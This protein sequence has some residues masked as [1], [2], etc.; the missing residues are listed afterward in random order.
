MDVMASSALSH[1]YAYEDAQ[2]MSYLVV[3]SRRIQHLSDL[4]RAHAG[5]VAN[6]VEHKRRIAELKKET[7][8]FGLEYDLLMSEKMAMEQVW[9]TL[10]VNVDSLTKYNEGLMIH[11]ESLSTMLLTGIGLL[12]RPGL[13]LRHCAGTMIGFCRLGLYALW[14]S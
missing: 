14:I 11:N 6:E 2:A 13:K 8:S 5:F 1:N 4:E 9:S 3:G 7:L 12:K 10:E